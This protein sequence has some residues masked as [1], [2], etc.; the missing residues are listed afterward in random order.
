MNLIKKLFA[1]RP[2]PDENSLA[3][4][5]EFGMPLEDARRL[6]QSSLPIPPSTPPTRSAD[7]PPGSP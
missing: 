4:L 1:L 3:D 5:Y 2:G 6:L 7:G